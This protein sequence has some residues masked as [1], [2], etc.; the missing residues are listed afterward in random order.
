M[1]KR[2][3][4]TA[5]YEE[6]KGRTS[7][8]LSSRK[9]KYMPLPF[10]KAE[11]LISGSRA[12]STRSSHVHR[13]YRNKQIAMERT[14]RKDEG[15]QER[16]INVH[17]KSIQS[18]EDEPVRDEGVELPTNKT[19]WHEMWTKRSDAT[20]AEPAVT[21]EC[22]GFSVKYR[23]FVSACNKVTPSANVGPDLREDSGAVEWSWARVIWQLQVRHRYF[24]R[25][26]MEN[27]KE[28]ISLRIIIEHT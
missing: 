11:I 28:G 20:D 10:R 26:Q 14:T 7:F 6:E 13:R 25:P 15:E 21:V 1:D 4:D 2:P 5:D 17:K 27:L 18:R 16:K 8:M 24:L 22:D 3:A 9:L 23:A 12:A 19:S